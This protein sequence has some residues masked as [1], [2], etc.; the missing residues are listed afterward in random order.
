M[1]SKSLEDIPLN[2]DAAVQSSAEKLVTETYVDWDLLRVDPSDGDKIY[3]NWRDTASKACREKGVYT[4]VS[5]A[6]LLDYEFAMD[7]PGSVD[8]IWKFTKF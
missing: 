7:C 4:Y 2:T 6:S 8:G 5:R 1:N 3:G